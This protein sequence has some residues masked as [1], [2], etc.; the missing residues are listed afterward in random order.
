MYALLHD[1]ESGREQSVH[2]RLLTGLSQRASKGIKGLSRT[3][4]M[5]IILEWGMGICMTFDSTLA[6]FNATLVSGMYESLLPGVYKAILR[7]HGNIVIHNSSFEQNTYSSVKFNLHSIVPT[8]TFPHA[9]STKKRN[10]IS[11]SGRPLLLLHHLI[12]LRRRSQH[13]LCTS[14]KIL[15]TRRRAGTEQRPNPTIRPSRT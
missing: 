6:L 15:I 11:E 13:P 1:S 7:P 12:N 5:Q 3:S 9:V 4:L 8:V 14:F 2:E 10:I